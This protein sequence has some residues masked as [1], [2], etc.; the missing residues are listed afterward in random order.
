MWRTSCRLFSELDPRSTI[1]SVDEVGAFDNISRAAI[2]QGVADMP[3]GEKLIPFISRY[4]WENEVGENVDI[5]QGEGGEQGDPLM[6]MLFSLGQHKAL[7]AANAELREGERLMAFLDDVHVSTLPDRTSDAHA[8]L[9]E[10]LKT[11]SCC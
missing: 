5:F 8:A 11:G 1:L 3:H 4:L 6:P 9:G 2:F 10:H 7:V